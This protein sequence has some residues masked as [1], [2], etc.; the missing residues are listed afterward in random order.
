MRRVFR[1]TLTDGLALMAGVLVL[2]ALLFAGCNSTLRDQIELY[3]SIKNSG[4]IYVDGTNGDDANPGT[5]ELPKK[6]IQNAIDLAAELMGE[7]EVWV[8][9]GTYIV[10]APLVVREGISI[11]GGY[12][13][14]PGW[15][16][17]LDPAS[18][19]TTTIEGEGIDTVIRSEKGVTPATAIEG[20]TIQAADEDVVSCIWCDRCCPTIR[21]NYIDAS[22]GD[23][24]SVGIYNKNASPIINGNTI[25]AGGGSNGA[26]GIW[27]F[28]ASP[29][30]WNNVIYGQDGS[31]D[32]RGIYNESDCD[33]LIQNN[34]IRV[35]T[36]AVDGVGIYN[37][38]STCLV[39]NNI[40]FSTDPVMGCAIHDS[41]NTPLLEALNNNDFHQCAVV[42]GND[43]VSK[44]FGTMDA[45]LSGEGVPVSGNSEEDPR[46][47]D[48]PGMD[49]WHWILSGDDTG[50][51]VS[52]GGKPLSTLFTNDRKA[53][54]RIATWS[55]GAYEKD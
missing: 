37:S 16:P 55:M 45:Y 41:A 23:S 44:D 29:K 4:I 27:N 17:P 8:A 15:T 33:D 11:L 50:Q 34:T 42:Y 10:Y 40:F 31:I 54:T 28:H 48:L 21:Y 7:G 18:K 30:I 39:E 51:A 24:Y 2:T 53:D 26:F 14:F 52:E 9:E 20:F 13:G 25:N 3:V 22:E 32:F 6:S 36:A 43:A 1:T 19:P 46:F 35:G 38:D 12:S 5:P 49:P 47:D